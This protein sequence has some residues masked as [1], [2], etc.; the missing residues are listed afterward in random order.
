MVEWLP[1]HN[2]VCFTWDRICHCRFLD[3]LVWRCCICQTQSF[4]FACFGAEVLDFSRNKFCI[5]HVQSSTFAN[6]WHPTRTTTIM[7]RS[8]EN[9]KLWQIWISPVC[10]CRWLELENTQIVLGEIQGR[11]CHRDNYSYWG[12]LLIIIIWMIKLCQ[13]HKWSSHPGR[14]VEWRIRLLSGA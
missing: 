7:R 5:F 6:R 8:E 11:S 10:K 13:N 12:R 3:F 9:N 4:T 2:L 14:I 1:S